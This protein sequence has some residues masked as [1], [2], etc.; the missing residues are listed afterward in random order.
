MKGPIVSI[1]IPVRNAE[2]YIERCVQSVQAQTYADLDIILVLNDS[3]DRSDAICKQLGLADRRI[4]LL[5]TKEAG[6]SKA[7]NLGIASASG[8]YIMFIDADDYI[9]E[10]LVERLYSEA[11][12]YQADI[13]AAGFEKYT[14]N[15]L[16]GEHTKHGNYSVSAN[17]YAQNMLLGRSGCDGY[18]WGKLYNI[19]ALSKI[20]FNE[21]LKFSEDTDFLLNILR[22]D[23]RI[24]ISPFIGYFYSQ[25]TS[26]ITKDIAG[27]ERLESLELSETFVKNAA[28]SKI[29]SAAQCYCWRNGLYILSQ[30]NIS[31]RNQDIV[32]GVMK[33]HRMT[34][35]LHKLSPLKYRLI[36][37]LSLLGKQVFINILSKQ[38][39]R[40]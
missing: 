12:K 6:V 37:L 19:N 26:G 35:I 34:V 32:W 30:S 36:A 39:S 5:T 33:T 38:A 2:K 27:T 8:T 9:H 21:T 28:D 31:T 7:R 13:V 4:H 25:D 10:N 14:E 22:Q 3:S 29:R 18:I 40:K 17:D 15:I 1:V 16:G 23:L 20:R 11:N 24:F